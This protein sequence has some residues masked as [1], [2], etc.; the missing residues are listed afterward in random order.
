MET[1]TQ[2]VPRTAVDRSNI[3]ALLGVGFGVW[4][5][6]TAVTRL[7]GAA[8]LQPSTPLVTVA[9]YGLM[10]PSM[11]A[12]V[13]VTF[14][15]LDVSG[16]ARATAAILLVLPGMTLDSVLLPVFA[17]AFPAVEASMAGA[18]GGIVLVAYA[19]V[20]ATGLLNS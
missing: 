1:N 16:G 17:T 20:L 12:L 13:L 10:L 3:G 7:F 14:R 2:H 19:A 5:A 8:L 4:V 15:A 6:A 9:L 18:F 11:A